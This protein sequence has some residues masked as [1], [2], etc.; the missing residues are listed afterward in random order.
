MFAL[1]S[2]VPEK[3]MIAQLIKK[4]TTILVPGFSVPCL[5]KQTIGPH[6]EPAA[7]VP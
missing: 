5:L 1:L 2:A 3:L 7:E 4:F 6:S